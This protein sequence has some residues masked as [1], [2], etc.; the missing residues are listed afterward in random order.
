MRIFV[1]I[2]LKIFKPTTND[3]IYNSVGSHYVKFSGGALMFWGG[4]FNFIEETLWDI[5]TS[6]VHRFIVFLSAS[7]SFSHWSL[8]EVF[9]RKQCEITIAEFIV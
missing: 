1:G 2:A 5:D 8:Q 4:F 6:I 3:M 9:L 7:V